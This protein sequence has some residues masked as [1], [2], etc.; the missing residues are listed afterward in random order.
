M[1]TAIVERML[2]GEPFLSVEC[3]EPEGIVTRSVRFS[4]LDANKIRFL[5]EKLSQFDTLFDDYIR[6]DFESF[7]KVFMSPLP[8]GDVEAAGLVWEV[9]DVGILYLTNI[10]PNV[11]ALV[12]AAFWDRRL[13]GREE[14]CREMIRLLMD[15]FDFHRLTARIGLYSKATLDFVERVGF[16]KEGRLRQAT[17][18]KGEW[19]DVNIYSILKGEV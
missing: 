6:D 19:F 11:E 13:K 2:S 12:H 18:F 17:L 4:R 5:Y 7:L 3:Q 9:D 15:Q 14:L 1:T 8:D 16:K 10:V